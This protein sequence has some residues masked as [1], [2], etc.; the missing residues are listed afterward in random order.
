MCVWFPNLLTATKLHK[1]SYESSQYALMDLQL[2]YPSLPPKA[3]YISVHFTLYKT[4]LNLLNRQRESGEVC[5][6][7]REKSCACL[8]HHRKTM[9]RLI[10]DTY[11]FPSSL[12]PLLETT[13]TTNELTH[14]THS[15]S[16]SIKQCI[17]HPLTMRKDY[18]ICL[19]ITTREQFINTF[20][21]NNAFSIV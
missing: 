9:C 7:L 10:C 13:H 12:L 18:Q 3:N 1:I 6:H 14:N 5:C 15:H 16:Q 11:Y 2:S 21:S 19:E 20:S 8:K 4:Q 17:S